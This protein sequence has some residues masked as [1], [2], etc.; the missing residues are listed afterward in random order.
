MGTSEHDTGVT[1]DP[2]TDTYRLHHDWR[3]DESV[4]AA[5]VRG[6][7]AVTNTAPTE[8]DPLFETLD[9]DALDQLYRSTARGPGRGDCWVS[10][11]YNDCAVTVAA[12]GEIAIAPDGVAEPVSADVP[13]SLR[14]R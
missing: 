8:L 1:F 13:R 9:P 12:T 4:S 11:C 14:D 2:D 6:V 5:V 3:G 10:F 7:A